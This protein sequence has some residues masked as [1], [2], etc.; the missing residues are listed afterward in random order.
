MLCTEYNIVIEPYFHF[1]VRP[2]PEFPPEIRNRIYKFLF[3][4][5]TVRV[6]HLT[7]KR[8]K[9]IAKIRREVAEGHNSGWSDENPFDIRTAGRLTYGCRTNDGVKDILNTCRSV[10][11]E[12]RPMLY[13]AAL[14]DISD[15]ALIETF[16]E[17]AGREGLL[18]CIK[19]LRLGYVVDPC[20]NWQMRFPKLKVLVLVHFEYVASLEKAPEGH[21]A[22]ELWSKI[23][24]EKDLGELFESNKD[25]ELNVVL[26]LRWFSGTSKERLA[27]EEQCLVDVGEE[28]VTVTPVSDWVSG[29]IG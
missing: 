18:T 6:R 24:E 26:K 2:L 28:R 11:R 27:K 22:E 5:S 8:A 16:R 29:W 7:L 25:N 3:S 14:W 1:Q 21:S 4:G 20:V 13:G 17:E 10:R 19:Y 23:V 9:I 15:P 12:A